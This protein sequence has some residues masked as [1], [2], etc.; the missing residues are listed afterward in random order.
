MM[1]NDYRNK[2]DAFNAGVSRK[3]VLTILDACCIIDFGMPS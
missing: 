3:F 2:L 1:E